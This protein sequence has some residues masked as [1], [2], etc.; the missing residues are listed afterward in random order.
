MNC[1]FTSYLSFRLP[2]KSFAL[3]GFSVAMTCKSTS[4]DL[5]KSILK[6]PFAG[7]HRCAPLPDMGLVRKS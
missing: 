3:E 5:R 1:N 2:P 4:Q 6:T 7:A